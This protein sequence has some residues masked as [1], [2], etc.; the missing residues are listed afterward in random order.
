MTKTYLDGAANTPLSRAAYRAMRPFF[1]KR[2]V[3]NSMSTHLFGVANHTALEDARNTIAHLTHV[4]PD[5]V[6]FTSGATEGNNW[7]IKSAAL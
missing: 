5:E 4:S 1:T 3:G 6:F 2:G 7:A